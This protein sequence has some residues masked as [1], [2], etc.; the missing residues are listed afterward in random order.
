MSRCRSVQKPKCLRLREGRDK[1]RIRM[2]D[3]KIRMRLEIT[4]AKGVLPFNFYNEKTFSTRLDNGNVC[5]YVFE[6]LTI[7]ITIDSVA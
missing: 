6:M 4:I 7:N 1:T 2:A 3:E 5:M